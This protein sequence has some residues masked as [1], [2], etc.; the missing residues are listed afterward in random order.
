VNN[1]AKGLLFLFF[2]VFC[3]IIFLF[4]LIFWIILI[5]FIIIMPTVILQ[6]RRFYIR[7]LVYVYFCIMFSVTH[8]LTGT[9]LFVHS[10]NSQNIFDDRSIL[11]AS[12]HYTNVDW[13]YFSWSYVFLL[14]HFSMISIVLKR[15]FKN[16]PFIGWWMQAMVYTFMSRKKIKDI[17]HIQKTVEYLKIVDDYP[18]VLIF[19]EGTVL[20]PSATTA[21][22][23]CNSFTYFTIFFFK[24]D[25][26]F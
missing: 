6:L 24:L 25:L 17:P 20:K 9:K 1:R 19:P 8:D 16:I 3:A 26:I 23:E 15:R 11:I 12:N 14:N 5:P 13:M 2:L 4:S 21:S 7:A 10:N 22:N 18:S